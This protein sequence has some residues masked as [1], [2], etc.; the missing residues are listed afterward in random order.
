M[1]PKIIHYVYITDKIQRY[2]DNWKKLMLD[3]QFIH[4]N[5]E[6]FDIES[7]K[8]VK[9][10][11]KAEKWRQGILAGGDAD[12]ANYSQKVKDAGYDI[13]IEAKKLEEFYEGVV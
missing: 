10:A 11:M 12:R 5:R 6:N 3:Y 13:K 7:V 9:Q 1:I 4:W 8:W 2:I